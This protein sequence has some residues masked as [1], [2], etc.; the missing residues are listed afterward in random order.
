MLKVV[1]D[2]NQFVSSL[3]VKT[4]QPAQLIE[5]WKNR[6]FVL[7]TSA[8]ILSEI[9]QTLSYSRIRKKYPITDK[10][11]DALIAL[12]RSEAVLVPGHISVSVIKEDPED[13]K[14]LACA[15]EGGSDYIVS[16]DHHLKRLG[17]YEGI[18]IVTVRHFLEIIGK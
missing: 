8:E 13:D 14:I 11:I 3:L 10:D 15:I 12:L 7:I 4:G 9:R 18:P 1:L 2:T 17:S 16:G 5:L 6:A